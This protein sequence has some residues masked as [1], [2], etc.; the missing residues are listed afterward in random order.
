MY[1]ED[2]SP[3]K[4]KNNIR[5]IGWLDELHPFPKGD[6]S[7]RFFENLVLIFMRE[8]V[9]LTRGWHYCELCGGE[10]I[11]MEEYEIGLL[12][13]AEIWVPDRNSGMIYAAP[14]LILHYIYHHD[15]LPPQEFI[16]AVMNFDF[17]SDWSAE[18]LS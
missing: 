12:G 14:E 15:Y 16:N 1:H 7:A 18:H 6:L 9:K 8:T 4:E 13:H 17:D 10:L 2:L 11:D 3:Y 5:R